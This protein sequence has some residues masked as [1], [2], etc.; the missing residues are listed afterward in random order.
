MT[1][2]VVVYDVS[3]DGIR[4]RMAALLSGHGRRV[5][6]SVFECRLAADD[7]P[8]LAARL[9]ALLERPEEGNVRLYRVCEACFG[10]SLGV[11]PVAEGGSGAYL[12]V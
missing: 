11:G 9:Q 5:Q 10:A 4:G 7:V 6:E 3:D 8:R 1:T 12:V 2:W